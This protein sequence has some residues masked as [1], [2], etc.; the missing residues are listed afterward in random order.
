MSGRDRLIGGH[1]RDDWRVR[2]PVTGMHTTGPGLCVSLLFEEFRLRKRY[3][4]IEPDAHR[5]WP[6]FSKEVV[7]TD[8]AS[9]S[10]RLAY[11][12]ECARVNMEFRFN[13]QEGGTEVRRTPTFP[14]PYGNQGRQEGML[15]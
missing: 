10:R 4:S 8:R 9:K 3:V 5:A 2:R 1:S 13:G 14:S 11:R 7:L 15:K 6:A 12:S